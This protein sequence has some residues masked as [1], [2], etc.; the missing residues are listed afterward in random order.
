MRVIF[1]KFKNGGDT[2]AWLPDIEANPGRCMAYQHVGQHGEGTYPADTIP[3]TAE[4]AAPLL[5]ELQ[6]IY[7]PE[8]LRVVRK[9]CQWQLGRQ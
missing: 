6:S 8:S 3:A 5:A 9:L 7:A 4:E 2:I 1:R